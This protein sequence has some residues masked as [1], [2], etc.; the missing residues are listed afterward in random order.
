M[1]LLR[2]ARV[3][4]K[5]LSYKGL[6]YR[7]DW[8]SPMRISRVIPIFLAVCL[9]GV[10]LI[11]CGPE[12]DPAAVAEEQITAVRRGDLTIDITTVGN[13]AFSRQEE[14]TFKA[15]GTI[16]EVLVD[17]GDSV[18]GGQRLARLDDT[19]TTSLQQAVVR[20][21]IELRE[22]ESAVAVA[23]TQAEAAVADARV[24]LEAAREA[25]E[26]TE[27]TESDIVQA[28]LAVINAEIALDRAED[29]FEKAR[30]KYV[31]NRS[32][33][34]RAQDYRQ[35]QQ[36]LEIA[37]F[38][39]VDAEETLAEVKAGADP[40]QVEQKQQQLALAQANLQE[41]EET[42]AGRLGVELKQ[43]EVASARA[44]LDEAIERLEMAAMAAPFA[45]VVTSVNA[46]SGETVNA[47]QVI[48]ELAD[49]DKFEVEVL[50]SE[51]DIFDIR[52]GAPATIQVDAVSAVSLPAEVTHISPIATIQSGVVSYEVKV[53]IESLQAIME[54]GRA[55]RQEAMS[56]I[57]SGELADRVKQA[58]EAG[59]ISSE[60]AEEMM[61]QRQPGQ[62]AMP[63]MIP[64]EL[65][66]KEGLTVT[67]SII[68]EER[69][70]VLLVPNSAV[71][72]SAG[73]SYVKVVSAAGAIEDR[74][75][76]IGISDWQYTEVVD[77]LDEGERV[78]VPG[79]TT[80]EAAASS[81]RPR[82]I[83]IPGMGAMGR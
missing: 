61:K 19:S 72:S 66:L 25:L 9:V 57:S 42:L 78:V 47:D 10:L 3:I 46:E 44:A 43:S 51:M 64:E 76:T 80:A 45:G 70:D 38:D 39:L 22:A 53:E 6:I 5:S 67:I 52:L 35:K 50:V 13:L 15:E 58:I 37:E 36:E 23:V 59:L 34:E 14:L 32:V 83:R 65:R 17:V 28:E 12:S 48:I 7:K 33:P 54:E 63:A 31:Q 69:N 30:Y 68:L 16:G 41:T 62:P 82:G 11:S 4:P 24:A 27:Y 74:P 77:G 8:V 40:L 49:P 26:D 56:G 18:A 21:K 75:V 71:T 29:D 2:V 79:G 20:A 73:Q 1:R 60:Q 81:A 55:A